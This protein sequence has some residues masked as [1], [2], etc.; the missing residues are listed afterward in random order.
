VTLR[1]F[2]GSYAGLAALLALLEPTLS[3]TQVSCQMLR[4]PGLEW[5]CL[6]SVPAM[7]RVG[8]ELILELE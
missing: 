3:N 7:G 5:S 4:E 6:L 1:V 8:G 2:L